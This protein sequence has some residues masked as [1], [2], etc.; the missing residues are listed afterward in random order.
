[1]ARS[2]PAHLRTLH[3]SIT[4][5][6][7]RADVWHVLLDEAMFRRWAAS[8]AE[9]SYSQG[10]WSEGGGVRFLTH[11]GDGVLGVIADNRPPERLP[12]KH[13]GILNQGID[14]TDSNAAKSWAP[15]YESYT[16]KNIDGGTELTVDMNVRPEYEGVFWHTSPRALKAISTF[17]EAPTG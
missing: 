1:M 5:A 16:L 14:D 12:I 10:D 13:I 8:F 9:A 4:I 2:A 6:A 7:S 15:A 3:F 11:D 17:A